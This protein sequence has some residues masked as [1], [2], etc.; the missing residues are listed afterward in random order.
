MKKL[1][2]DTETL[3][4]IAK[5]KGDFTN[6]AAAMAA[7][8]K[9]DYKNT[10][11]GG[12]NHVAFFLDSAKSINRS[13]ISIYDQGM[14]EEIQKAVQGLLRRQGDQGQGAGQLLH[15]H[16]R[17]V[18]QPQEVIAL[19]RAKEAGRHLSVPLRSRERREGTDNGQA[20]QD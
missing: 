12:Q 18:S 6:N 7:V 3:T 1:T 17:E 4:T 9:S 13:N 11:L 2:C 8:A 19:M 20:D 10:F 16:P 14:T 15:R 5:E